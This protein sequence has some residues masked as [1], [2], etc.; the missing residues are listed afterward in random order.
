MSHYISLTEQ[1]RAAMLEA[2]GV[3]SV[4]ELFN[5]VPEAVRFPDLKLPPPLS[6]PEL[7]RELRKMSARNT[8][9]V[10]S[11]VFR[12]AGAYNH[13]IPAAVDAILRRAEYYTSYT[14]H[15]PELSQGTL[16]AIFEYQTMI[17][18]LTGMDVANASHYDG[19]TALAEAAI[20]ALHS[21]RNK[22]TVI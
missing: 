18:A 3:S 6:E 12:G 11:L 2:I 10:S 19:A 7:M 8:D 22:R 5:V 4:H 16:Q 17:C 13:F 9:A 14:P 20:M 15:Q 1:D 21:T